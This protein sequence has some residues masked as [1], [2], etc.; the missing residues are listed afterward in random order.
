MLYLGYVG[1]SI[2]YSFAAAAL[3]EGPHRRGLGAIS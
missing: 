1:F 3:I 2:V